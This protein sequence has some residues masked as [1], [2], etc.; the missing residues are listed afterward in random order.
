LQSL[1]GSVGLSGSIGVG[2]SGSAIT[3][4]CADSRNM[5]GDEI[6]LADG[7]EFTTFI[8]KALFS[9]N[10]TIVGALNALAGAASGGVKGLAVITSSIAANANFTLND[11]ALV[12]R[13][14]YDENGISLVEV[15]VANTDVFVNGQ[16]LAAGSSTSNGDYIVQSAANPGILRFAFQ[17]VPDDVIIVKTTAQQ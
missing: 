6:R 16:L 11:A 4:G 7:G 8:G 12:D 15:S 3:F 5:Q 2:M 10:T 9:D 13:T 1:L 17:L 14:G